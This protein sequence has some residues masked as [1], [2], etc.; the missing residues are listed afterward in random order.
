VQEIR[1]ALA[2]GPPAMAAVN[3]EPPTVVEDPGLGFLLRYTKPREDRVIEAAFKATPP[4]QYLKT[5]ANAAHLAGF[6][7]APTFFSLDAVLDH[8][9]FGG[10]TYRIPDAVSRSIPLSSKVQI[11]LAGESVVE[12]VW[13]PLVRSTAIGYGDKTERRSGATGWAIFAAGLLL[14]TG[15]GAVSVSINSNNV[16]QGDG[17]ARD[18]QVSYVPTDTPRGEEEG[19]PQ[20]QDQAGA[21]VGLPSGPTNS[22]QEDARGSSPP[23]PQ[24]TPAPNSTLGDQDGASRPQNQLDAH[25]STAPPQNVG[26]QSPAA[27]AE[28]GS[29]PRRR[30]AEHYSY[31][32]P[33]TSVPPSWCGATRA[34]LNDIE[35]IICSNSALYDYD[36]RLNAVYQNRLAALS[37]SARRNLIASERAW[38][39][40]RDQVCRAQRSMVNCLRKAYKMRIQELD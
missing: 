33:A 38:I 3:I 25:V 39:L 29:E 9:N 20:V 31:P 17:A 26:G 1:E 2:N 7:D 30:S 28:G 35:R 8:G 19:R 6:D 14:I 27:S 23:E 12:H 40:A 32:E 5:A 15:L 36:N 16:R 18:A 4:G 24:D 21:Q 37:N 13:A 11:E 34:A 22:H 10:T